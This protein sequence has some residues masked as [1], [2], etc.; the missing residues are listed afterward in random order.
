MSEKDEPRC[1]LYD[2]STFRI[3]TASRNGENVDIFKEIHE[4][5]QKDAAMEVICRNYKKQYEKYCE[6]FENHD[7]RGFLLW[8]RFRGTHE[9]WGEGE[10]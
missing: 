6:V 7:P 5:E 4:Q 10:E 1:T 2:N 3:V 9:M 8:G